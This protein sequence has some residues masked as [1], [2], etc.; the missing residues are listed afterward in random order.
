MNYVCLTL[1]IKKRVQRC[2]CSRAFIVLKPGFHITNK[3]RYQNNE[4]PQ[5][6]AL[7]NLP[8]DIFHAFLS[9]ADF[10]QN[11]IFQRNLSGIPSEYP[12]QA[13]IL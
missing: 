13:D 11:Q 12:D 2:K 3:D 4:R 5:A 6:L 10:F 8:W 7:L 1:C 9:S